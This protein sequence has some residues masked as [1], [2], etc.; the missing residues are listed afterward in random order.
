MTT[1]QLFAQIATDGGCI[2]SSDACST[3]EIAVAQSCGRFAVDD[4]GLGYVR[5]PKEWL[6]TQGHWAQRAADL[7]ELARDLKRHA[8]EAQEMYGVHAEALIEHAEEVLTKANQP[9]R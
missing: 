1:T 2:V 6:A 3:L 4:S 9:V 8:A 5:R 7:D